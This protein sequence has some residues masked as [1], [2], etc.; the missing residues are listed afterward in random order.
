MDISV[1][2]SYFTT[3]L[4]IFIAIQFVNVV[5]STVKSVMTVNGDKW[6]ASLWN[7]LSYCFG[8]VVTKMITQQSFEVII[9]VSA[10]TNLIGTYFGKWILEKMRRERLWTVN[11]TIRN[12]SQEYVENEFLKRGI[13]YTLLPAVNDRMLLCAYSYSKAE[14]SLVKEILEHERVR[15]TVVESI[16]NSEEK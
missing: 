9:I 12:H 7:A 13:Q 8:A 15:Y 2:T 14:S 3:D 1:L 16:G 11:A 10:I 4:A 5:L 6:S